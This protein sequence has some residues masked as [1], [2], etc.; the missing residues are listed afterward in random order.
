MLQ[1]GHQMSVIEESS[2]TQEPE[3]INEPSS[4]LLKKLN[5]YTVVPNDKIKERMRHLYGPYNSFFNM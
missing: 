1:P 2:T 5:D 4:I 3:N